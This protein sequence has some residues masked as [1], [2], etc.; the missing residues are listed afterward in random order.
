VGLPE[1][2]LAQTHPYQTLC[3]NN[4]MCLVRLTDVTKQGILNVIPVWQEVYMAIEELLKEELENS[5]R[6]ERDYQLELA[7]LPRGCLV[8][9]QIRGRFYYYVAAREKDKVRFRYIGRKM[10]EK[11]VARFREA[12]KYRV[13]YRSLLSQ[14]RRQIKF[15]RRALRA[16]QTV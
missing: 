5:L 12:K 7:K 14:L 9:K 3:H 2:L 6:M 10:E 4:V 15:I 8:K 16:K 1:L 11:D 13:Q